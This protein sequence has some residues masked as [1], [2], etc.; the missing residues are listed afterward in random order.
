M[1]WNYRIIQRQEGGED[2]F[3]IHECHYKMRGAAV[4]DLWS[5][6]PVK[7]YGE[8]PDDLRADLDLMA[9][10]FDKPILREVGDG[11]EEVK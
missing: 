6:V 4:P 11:L 5:S 8:T 3:G 9:R 1:T 7:P 2:R 10:A